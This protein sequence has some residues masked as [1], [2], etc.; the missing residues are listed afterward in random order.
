MQN[1]IPVDPDILLATFRYSAASM[2]SLADI[3]PYIL[4]LHIIDIL[5]PDIDILLKGILQ[6][7]F[8]LT[9]ILLPYILLPGINCQMFSCH[10][11]YSQIVNC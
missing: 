6:S 5:L 9:N 4:L 3:L 11:F 10:I 7:E 1:I 8:Q 2:R